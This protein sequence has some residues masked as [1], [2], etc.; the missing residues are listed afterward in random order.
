MLV[1]VLNIIFL[2]I[3][4]WYSFCNPTIF[5]C[6]QILYYTQFLGFIPTEILIGGVDYGSFLI[7]IAI[8]LPLMLKGPFEKQTDKTTIYS[9]LFITFFMF[10][11]IIKPVFDGSQPLLMGIKAGKSFFSYILLFYLLIY[12]K[13]IYF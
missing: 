5:V 3:S 10:Y 6:L 8:F 9:I 2:L 1:I 7:N 4:V 13:S 11:G 12:R